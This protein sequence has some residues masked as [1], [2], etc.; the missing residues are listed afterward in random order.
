MLSDRSDRRI[1]NQRGNIRKG[2]VTEVIASFL[3]SKGDD[4]HYTVG[5]WMR[6]EVVQAGSPSGHG[7][8]AGDLWVETVVDGVRILGMLP[9]SGL[10]HLQ[11]SIIEGKRTRSSTVKIS[12]SQSLTQ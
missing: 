8:I 7:V 12:I 1:R 11:C 10:K 9:L 5:E 3:T 6:R 4:L 2:G